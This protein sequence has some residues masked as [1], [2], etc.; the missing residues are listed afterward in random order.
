M[1]LSRCNI[2]LRAA[3]LIPGCRSWPVLETCEKAQGLREGAHSGLPAFFPL[4]GICLWL[5][6]IGLGRPPSPGSTGACLRKLCN[7]SGTENT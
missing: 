6:S 3:D 2:R 1:Q 7:P 4:S 5:R